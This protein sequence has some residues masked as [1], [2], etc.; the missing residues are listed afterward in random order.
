M[1][2]SQARSEVK[3]RLAAM[4][5]E[6]KRC[7]DALIERI[8]SDYVLMRGYNNVCIY[9]ALPSEVATAGIVAR[10]MS[11]GVKICMPKVCGADMSL[12]YIDNVT[13]C[14]QG[15][16]GINEPVGEQISASSARLDA[17]ITPMLA[18]TDGKGRIGKGKGYYDRFFADIGRAERIGIAYGIQYI[19]GVKLDGFDVPMDTIITE[20]GLTN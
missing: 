1:D 5:A 15:A 2:K 19:G 10:L 4:G 6:E 13:R 17:V 20:K 3:R 11:A 7:A 8:A 9:N 14:E 18:Y 12:I 16:F